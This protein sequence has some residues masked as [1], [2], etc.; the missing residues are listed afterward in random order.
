MYAHYQYVLFPCSQVNHYSLICFQSFKTGNAYI[1]TQGKF[2]RSSPEQ[3]ANK[4]VLITLHWWA[5]SFACLKGE[6]SNF[7]RHLF[8]EIQITEVL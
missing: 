8:Q 7:F 1:A 6:C 3:G 4:V 5:L 2:N